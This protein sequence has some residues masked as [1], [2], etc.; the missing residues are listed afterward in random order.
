MDE[1]LLATLLREQHP[2]LAH[3]PVHVAD[4]ASIRH[5]RRSWDGWR[6]GGVRAP[7]NRQ[8]STRALMGEGSGSRAA[9]DRVV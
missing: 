7:V 6:F 3:L 1:G 9:A 4:A 5:R 8:P 2:D